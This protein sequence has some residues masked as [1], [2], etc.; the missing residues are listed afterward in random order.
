MDHYLRG[1]VDKVVDHI[2]IHNHGLTRD[3]II[4]GLLG[5]R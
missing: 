1:A 3:D 5:D 4:E 2:K